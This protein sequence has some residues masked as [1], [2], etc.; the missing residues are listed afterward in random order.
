MLVAE[1]IVAGYVDEIDILQEVSLRVLAGRIVSVI[2]PNGSGKSTLV[3]VICG[4]LTPKRGEVRYGDQRLTGLPAHRMPALGI[5]YLPQ[6]RTVF[7][8]L[9]VEQNIKLGAWSFRRDGGRVGTM[10][11]KIYDQFPLM[12][13]RRTTKAGELS[14]GMQKILEIARALMIEPRLL[15]FDEPTVGLAPIVAREVYDTLERLKAE[16]MTV[17]LVD[18]NVREAVRIGD[19]VYVLELGRNKVD[20]ARRDFEGDL[21][22]LIK[23]WLQI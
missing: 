2:G 4:M 13:E 22:A 14:G 7:P 19:H 11:Q 9:T 12:R 15:V 20:G 6:E 1:G 10:L 23:D 5:A 18:Q 17:L 3:R 8:H 16:G 21:Q